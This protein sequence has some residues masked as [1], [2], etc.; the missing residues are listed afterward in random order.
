MLS[1]ITQDQ[2]G[3]WVLPGGPRDCSGPRASRGALGVVK[4]AA[5]RSVVEKE[6]E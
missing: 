6:R 5:N 4:T 3:K 2:K 1:K